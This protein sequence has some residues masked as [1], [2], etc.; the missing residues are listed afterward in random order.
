[1]LNKLVEGWEK[2]E[3]VLMANIALKKPFILLG[4]HGTS[5]T[6]CAKKI[7]SIYGDEGYRFYDATK[8]DLVSIAGIPVPQK[9]AEGKL[10]FSNHDRTIWGAKTIVVDELSRANKESQNLWLEIL[11]ERSCFGIKLNYEV[12]IATMNPESYASTFKIDGAL[13]DRFY[14]VIPVPE[15]QKG[16]PADSISKVLK[17][18]LIDARESQNREVMKE[19]VSEILHAHDELRADKDIVIGIIDYVS[20]F[21]EILLSQDET[22]VSPRKFIQCA[23]EIL[24]V[25]SY[26]KVMGEEEFLE[27]AAETA[28]IYT[29]SIPLKIKPETLLQIHETVKPLLNKYKLTELDKLHLGMG[30][31]N[32]DKETWQYVKNNLQRIKEHLPFDEQEKIFGKLIETQIDLIGLKKALDILGGHEELKR[33]VEGE[34]LTTMNENAASVIRDLKKYSIAQEE[35]LELKEKAERFLSLL[36]K[37]KIPQEI[38]SF[39]SSFNTDHKTELIDFLR[40]AEW[41]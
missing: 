18:N 1:M 12:F 29:I 28:L 30:K 38:V 39:L 40:T 22:Y 3:P 5:K 7:S 9:L 16:T 23:E 8:D 13:L 20:N 11:N 24:A 34:I 21:L 2:I 4:R 14:A 33:K 15:L 17:L 35:D 32:S 41:R 6:T 37:P 19:A 31:L 25:G 27:K 10:E 36:E 26:F